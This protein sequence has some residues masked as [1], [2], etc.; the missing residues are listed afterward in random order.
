MRGTTAFSFNETSDEA[1]S[2]PPGPAAIRSRCN[3]AATEKALRS[4]LDVTCDTGRV[5]IVDTM[6]AAVVKDFGKAL[7]IEEV[8]I[9]RPGPGQVLVEVDHTGVCHTDLHAMDGD[10]PIKPSPPFIPGHEGHGTV[11][12]LGSGV[13]ELQEGDSVGNAWLHRACGGCEH[14]QNGWETLCEQQ[15]NSGYTTNGSFAEYMLVDAPYAGRIPSSADPVAV[16]PI[17]CAGVTVYKGLKVTDVRPGQW[18]AISGI[19]GLGHLAVQYARAMGMR[20]AAI[21]VD[22]EKLALARSHGAEVTAN[23][24]EQ[25]P[26]E[27]LQDSIGGAHGVLVTAV[28]TTA[29]GQALRVVRRGATIV[30]NGL[31]PGE[32]GLPIFETVLKGLTVRGSIVG[33]RRD[34]AEALEFAE[35]GEVTSTASAEPFESVNDVLERMRAG[36]VQGRAVL[37]LAR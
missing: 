13:T 26:A 12:E 3:C 1:V 11:V 29:F 27:V 24:A 35:R 23:A 9:P 22:D 10:W 5:W 31:P 33:T 37:D 7:E 19:G 32:F 28:N 8:P 4:I 20:V 34:L 36:R 15:V 21:D 16:A 25:D 2:C 6:K 14:C 18:V 17:L 30:L